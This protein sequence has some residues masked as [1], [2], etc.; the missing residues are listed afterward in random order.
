MASHTSKFLSPSCCGA[1]KWTG[2]VSQVLAT[3]LITV[4]LLWATWKKRNGRFPLWGSFWKLG[5]YAVVIWLVSVSVTIALKEIVE[6]LEV[7]EHSSSI[8]DKEPKRKLRFPQ[9]PNLIGR[10]VPIEVR[11]L[12]DGVK[13]PHGPVRDGG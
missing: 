12:D 2:I 8:D 6:Y 7:E 13:P 10:D 1:M 3:L 9:W 11:D 5:L 4:P